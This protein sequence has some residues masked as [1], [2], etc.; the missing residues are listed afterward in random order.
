M[1]QQSRVKSPL[2]WLGLVC[3]AYT[4]V[5]ET[6]VAAGVQM[7]WWIGAIGVGLSAIMVYCNGNNPSIK[8]KY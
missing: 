2:F 4:A 5:V 8:G 3:C 6:G 1:E 7:P